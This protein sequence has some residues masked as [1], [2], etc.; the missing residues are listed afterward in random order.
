MQIKL[1]K[2]TEII[3]KNTNLQ[4]QKYYFMGLGDFFVQTANNAMYSKSLYSPIRNILLT[5]SLFCKCIYFLK[6]VNKVMDIILWKF[7]VLF[8]FSD[9]HALS[10][11][12][13]KFNDEY[14]A[15]V[16]IYLYAS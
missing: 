6:K 10:K 11:S 2:L 12:N 9:L 1:P 4:R 7:L 16:H 13:T 14:E 3:F 5:T 15:V 8:D